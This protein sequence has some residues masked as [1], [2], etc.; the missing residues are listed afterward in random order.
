MNSN[1]KRESGLT[2]GSLSGADETEGRKRGIPVSDEAEGHVLKG[3][4]AIPIGDDE[5]E[6]HVLKH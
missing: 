4:G 2:T 3:A 6:G 1:R 5:A